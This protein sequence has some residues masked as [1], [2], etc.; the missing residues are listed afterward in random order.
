MRIKLKNP[1]VWCLNTGDDQSIFQN[2]GFLFNT[3]VAWVGKQSVP[4]G[5]K[6]GYLLKNLDGT[7]DT[8]PSHTAACNA[9]NAKLEEIAARLFEVVEDDSQG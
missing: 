6:P 2:A 7:I 1:I 5:Q 8:F 4:Q 9:A 3:A